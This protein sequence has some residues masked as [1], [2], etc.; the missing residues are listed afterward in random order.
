M[1]KQIYNNINLLRLIKSKSERKRVNNACG[2]FN[3]KQLSKQLSVVFFVLATILIP[4]IAGATTLYWVGSNG[5]NISDQTNW[6]T[7]NPSACNAGA[8]DASDYPK[9]SDTAVFD[10]DCDNNATIN[11]NWSAQGIS[12]QTGYS[13]TVT[14]SAGITVTIG[15]SGF[16]QAAGSFVSIPT[17]T[18]A[19]TSNFSLTG[20][21]FNRFTGSGTSG[22][23][24]LIFDVYG[25]Q[26]VNGYL[27]NYFQ[28]NNN[29][30]ASVAAS[31]NSSAGFSP[32]GTSSAPFAGNFNGN[33][34]TIQNLTIN[35]PSQGNVGLFGYVAPIN[36]SVTIQN[37]GVTGAS[38]TGGG[39][40]SV[41]ILV[42]YAVTYYNGQYTYPKV[43]TI[44]NCYSTGGV[45]ASASS[46]GVGGLI[47]Y[48]NASVIVSDSY[49]TANVT[50]GASSNCVSGL[51]GYNI[52][53]AGPTAIISN[54]Y[55]TGTVTAGAN[56]TQ[57]GGLV[58][59]N[60][61]GWDYGGGGKILNCYSTST[62]VAGDGSTYVGGLVGN[63][64]KWFPIVG[65]YSTGTVTAGANSSY[66]G[67]LV[68]YN[69]RSST[70]SDSYST[71]AV[72]SGT[73]STSVGGLV[74]INGGTYG[75]LVPYSSITDS[76]FTGTVTAN[77]STNVGGLVGKNDT[78]ARIY[79]S[80]S[81][82]TV[83]SSSGTNVG[84]WTG[85]NLSSASNIT[86]NAWYT[87]SYSVALGYD[88]N[89]SNNSVAT[90]TAGG[91]GYDASSAGSFYSQT[92]SVY[93]SGT[94]WNFTITW[95]EHNAVYP[96]LRWQYTYSSNPPTNFASSA[97]EYESISLS[98]NSFTN[99]ALT[100]NKYYF[101]RSDGTNSGWVS[102]PTWTDTELICGASYTHSV[103]YGTGDGLESDAVSLT[104][105]TL[106]CRISYS[107]P[108]V[109]SNSLIINQGAQYTETREVQLG[110]RA[111]NTANF[112]NMKISNNSQFTDSYLQPYQNTIPWTLTEGDGEKTVYTMFFDLQGTA[113]S[114]ISDTIILRTPSEQQE[115]SSGSG[116]EETL[117]K[118]EEV[119]SS[120]EETSE[121]E[122]PQ[123]I[124]EKP[125]SEM[126]TAEIKI[127]ITEIQQ[128]IIELL[129]QLIKLIQEQITQ[130]QA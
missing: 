61:Y 86:N 15:S 25:L 124:S 31:W 43:I 76:Y 105:S 21:T 5:G 107:Q 42:G 9:T 94:A 36:Q 32:I 57:V 103:K 50:S 22:S 126:T 10:P 37:V 28:L 48:A 40:G 80:Y 44:S 72:V 23:P 60:A 82:G 81:T 74:G 34:Y 59:R 53:Y 69:Y 8:G 30:D 68:G 106:P 91:Y 56:S 58:G 63:N 92:Y 104:T 49:S 27:S 47:G 130:L 51:V 46:L 77:S 12:M 24:Y 101:S 11:T 113:S 4:S 117:E 6:S 95:A 35:L 120:E 90:L 7:T 29:I 66:V 89:N 97:Q 109:I 88:S 39:S 114:I 100:A 123:V 121:E 111:I 71:G 75:G 2:I 116:E 84:G 64:D 99:T 110:L 67:G 1:T 128:N 55:S 20:G 19:S 52:S 3:S 83:T 85:Q 129:T 54:S 87:G 96:D 118:E 17:D 93:T 122:I 14:Q 115:T 13:G 70:I 65:S 16:V 38:V 102:S 78:S 79:N 45:T 108:Q 127:K 62:V 119:I 18:F 112:I 26:A 41:G 33:N 73:G 98:V 125:I